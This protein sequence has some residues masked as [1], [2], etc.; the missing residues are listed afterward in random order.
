MATTQ[1]VDDLAGFA[2]ERTAEDAAREAAY[3]ARVDASTALLDRFGIAPTSR[4]TFEPQPEPAPAAALTPEQASALSQ[5]ERNRRRREYEA[6]HGLRSPDP[7]P[8]QAS[9]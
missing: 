5:E 7:E 4:H 6:R 8:E 9:A 2:R 1:I 3:F